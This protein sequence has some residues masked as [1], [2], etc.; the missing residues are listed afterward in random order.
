MGVTGSGNG[1]T[2]PNPGRGLGFVTG[3]SPDQ[4]TDPVG[5]TGGE[6]EP[7]DRGPVEAPGGSMGHVGPQGDRS[8]KNEVQG[9][10]IPL[11]GQGSLWL[12][13]IRGGTERDQAQPTR[14]ECGS[15]ALTCD[16]V[17]APRPE[18]W[19]GVKSKI[20]L[21]LCAYAQTYPIRT[22]SRKKTDRS[23]SESGLRTLSP[24]GT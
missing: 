14:V 10:K 16:I 5:P 13:E 19:T 9:L 15:G 1:A 12:Q 6:G 24:T 22:S 8:P 23:D 7:T 17:T 21:T 2:E 4:R 18:T 20:S 3:V 11:V